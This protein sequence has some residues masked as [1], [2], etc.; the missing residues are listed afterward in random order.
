MQGQYFVF[1]NA[2]FCAFSKN[3]VVLG[4]LILALKEGGF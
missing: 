1:K 2:C 3:E 4:V